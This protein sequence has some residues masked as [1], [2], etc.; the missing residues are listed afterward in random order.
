MFNSIEKVNFSQ[1][2]NEPE[3][4][5]EYHSSRQRVQ[6]TYCTSFE[7]FLVDSVGNDSSGTIDVVFQDLGQFPKIWN[8]PGDS[9]TF[10]AYALSSVF[11]NRCCMYEL[12]KSD[13]ATF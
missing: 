6:C 9:R 3:Y 4:D 12:T 7:V 5:N 13:L 10:G 8:C 1:H 11:F 2:S